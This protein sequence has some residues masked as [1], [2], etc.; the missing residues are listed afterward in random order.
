MFLVKRIGESGGEAE[1]KPDGIAGGGG[2]DVDGGGAIDAGGARSLA[3]SGVDC[4]APN[5]PPT[6]SWDGAVG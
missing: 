2:V 6:S 1:V 5:R 3:K 4:E